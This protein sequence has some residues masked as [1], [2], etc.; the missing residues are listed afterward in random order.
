MSFL[1]KITVPLLIAFLMFGATVLTGCDPSPAQAESESSLPMDADVAGL[2]AE[3][4]ALEEEL[5]PLTRTPS[6]VRLNDWG[7]SGIAT[8]DF[9]GRYHFDLRIDAFSEWVDGASVEIYEHP[10]PAQGTRLIRRLAD[11][12]IVDLFRIW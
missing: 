3:K 9:S 2:V 7:V 12:T 5:L 8:K 10:D 1:S 6:M 4:E 11:G